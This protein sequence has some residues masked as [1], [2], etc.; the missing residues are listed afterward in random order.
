MPPYKVHEIETRSVMDGVVEL[1]WEVWYRPFM[2]HTPL[3]FPIDGYEHEDYLRALAAS[4]ERIW[5]DF[6]KRDQDNDRW[7]YV[8]DEA[9]SQ[10]VGCAIWSKLSGSPAPDGIPKLDFYWLKGQIKEFAEITFQQI[11]LP[12]CLWMHR[13]HGGERVPY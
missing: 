13:R 9:T 7:I 12:R 1:M 8:K 3:F 6:E 2:P 10:P 5:S 4:Q 11:L